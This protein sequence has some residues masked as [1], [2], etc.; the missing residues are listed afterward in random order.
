MEGTTADAGGRDVDDAALGRAGAVVV[1]GTVVDVA[2]GRPGAGADA[3]HA[4]AAAAD[5]GAAAGAAT[6]DGAAADEAAAADAARAVFRWGAAALLGAVGA[7]LVAVLV[8]TGGTFVH[9]LDDPAIH[10]AVARRLAFDGT[11]GVVAGEF[12]SASSSPLWTLVLAPTQ[13]V[14]R[15][16]AGEL[17]P[18][19]LNVACGLGVLRLLAPEAARAGLRPS[20]RRP[21]DALAVGVLVTGPLFLAGLAF[22]GMEHTLH[23]LLVL[24]TALATERR[25][26]PAVGVP[27]APGGRAGR[28]LDRPAAPF[29]LMALATLAR[30]ESA[31][32]AL[33]LAAALLAAARPALAPR[34]ARVRAGA[35]LVLAAGAGLAL[36]AALN[37]AFG[38]GPLPNSVI[39]KS[40]GDRGDTGRSVGAALGRLGTDP[41]LAAAGVVGLV[42]VVAAGARARRGRGAGAL[43]PARFPA[44]AVLVVAVMHAELGA[45]DP[46]LRYAAYA[47]TLGTWAALRAAPAAAQALAGRA[48]RG[49]GPAR[50]PV[51]VAVVVALLAVPAARQ[52]WA[53]ARVPED[54]AIFHQQRYQVARFL[55]GAYPEAP[56]AIG[57]LGYIALYHDGPLTDV[58]GLADHEVLEAT[59]DDRKDAAF[60]SRLRDERGF[61]VMVAYDFS[62]ADVPADWI[63]VADWVS[64]DAHFPVTRFWA[65]VPGEVA[66]LLAHLRAAEPGLPGGV[67]VAYNEMAGWA[68]DVALAEAAAG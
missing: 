10:L 51:A 23:A 8:R 45:V 53:T 7:L 58:Y 44:V 43:G 41:W 13:W 29:V 46:S 19:A 50:R 4:G 21:L 47:G 64:P 60:W 5:E 24:A 56:I 27:P 20:R 36:T 17:V 26:A 25:W 33:G 52:L 66:P 1:E 37:L 12:Q 32:V 38:Q 15:G 18:L 34:A 9:V 48:A 68:A 40:V 57:E 54:A 39:L 42:V 28:W 61:R 49:S 11:W 62:V 6:D 14:A 55:H 3:R 31:A 16:R 22:V 2:I 30:P 63:P 65:T 67:E 35:G 59:L